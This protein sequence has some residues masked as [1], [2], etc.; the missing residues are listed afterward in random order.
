MTVKI[1]LQSKVISVNPEAGEVCLEGG[2]IVKGDLIVGAD[3]LHSR[4]V[5][6]V[7]PSGRRIVDAGLNCFRFLVP[8]EKVKANPLAKAYVEG[9]LL[10]CLAFYPSTKTS[11]ITTSESPWLNAGDNE[12]LLSH[13]KDSQEVVREI[14]CMAE[15]LKL[16]KLTTRDLLPTFVKGKLALLGDAAHPMLPHRA[17]STGQAIED[18]GALG[19]V[20][21][22]GTQPEQVGELL[23]LYNKA[24]YEHA[25]AA[26]LLSRY[27]L[28]TNKDQ[29]QAD[30]E[31]FLPGVSVPDNEYAFLW[32][33]DPIQEVERLRK[34]MQEE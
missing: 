17:Q 22:E 6:A 28:G 23:D 31:T 25:I 15:D 33:S 19:A 16:Y 8:M 1:N 3:G 34:G 26:A 20:F 27:Y 14:C 11:E 12:K 18:A 9:T 13:F 21:G 29:T 30:F 5:A 32:C 24:R 2:T 4:T 7:L 10:N